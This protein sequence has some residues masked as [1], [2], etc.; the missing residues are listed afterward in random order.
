MDEPE[1]ARSGRLCWV[2][3][4]C[5]PLRHRMAGW[6]LLVPDGTFEPLDESEALRLLNFVNGCA[7]VS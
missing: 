5:T 2:E 4:S 3:P 7:Q 1:A 6:V